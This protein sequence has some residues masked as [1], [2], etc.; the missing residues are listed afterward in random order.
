MEFVY[1]GAKATSLPDGFMR[2]ARF[3]GHLGV[4]VSTQ[5][6][7]CLPGG[8]CLWAWGVYTPWADNPWVNT[9][10]PP[11]ACWDTHPPTHCILGYNTPPPMDRIL[12]TRL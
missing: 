11:I 8:V 2:T 9:V 7:G 3:N 5:G 12:D 6:K 1:I 10:T 4:G